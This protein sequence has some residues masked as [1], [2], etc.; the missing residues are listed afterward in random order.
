MVLHQF[1][2][3]DFENEADSDNSSLHYAVKSQNLEVIKY[4]L[5]M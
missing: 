3:I 1:N 4:L 5:L 2:I